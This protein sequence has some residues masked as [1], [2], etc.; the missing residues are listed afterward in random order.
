MRHI[1]ATTAAWLVGALVWTS[2]GCNHNPTALKA[3][4]VAKAERYAAEGQYPEAII[5]YRSAIK[6]DPADADAYHRL[7]LLYLTRNPIAYVQPA[8]A[9]LSKAVELDPRLIDAQLKLGE[10]FLLGRQTDAAEAKA[11][12]VL[13]T[14]PTHAGGLTLLA[15]SALEAKRWDQAAQAVNAAKRAHPNDPQPWITEASIAIETHD[16]VA[17]ERAYLEA[18]RLA[19]GSVEVV[20]GLGDLYRL[21]NR[22]REAETQSRRA[23]ELQPGHLALRVNWARFYAASRDLPR[24]EAVFHEAITSLTKDP[25]A[26][27][28]YAQ[29]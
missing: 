24:A 19:P 29:H 11:K 23:V 1:T 15:R 7:G 9:A 10:L 3:G 28:A 21:Q 5:E 8:F 16:Y 14:D 6:I 22:N 12:L 18:G 26:R 2:V 25:G 20:T 17:A 27:M 4:H 13:E